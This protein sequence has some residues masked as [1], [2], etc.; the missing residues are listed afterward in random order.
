[1][2]KV[3][4]SNEIHTLGGKT[5]TTTEKGVYSDLVHGNDLHFAHQGHEQVI[6]FHSVDYAIITRTSS[7]ATEPEDTSCVAEG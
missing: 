2:T 3:T 6:P 1:M 4:I 5:F 7:E